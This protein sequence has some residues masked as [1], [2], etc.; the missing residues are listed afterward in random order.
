MGISF[1]YGGQVTHT[2]NTLVCVTDRSYS[3]EK[4]PNICGAGW[5]I[6][7]T[8]TK[9]SI[10]ATLV[11][12][13]DSASAYRRDLLGRFAIHLILYAIEEYYGVT[14]GS[15]VLCDNKW[16]L[17]TSKKKSKRIPAGAKTTTSKGYYTAGEEQ[18]EEH[19]VT[20][21]RQSTSGQLQEAT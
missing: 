17:Y 19:P 20:P 6:Y 12:R 18:N 4:S 13:S 9:H 8:A 11:E 16:A 5:I 15:N 21:P 7:C 14:G 3:L 1:E 10:S 2:H